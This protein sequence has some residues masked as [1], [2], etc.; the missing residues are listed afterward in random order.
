[1]RKLLPVIVLKCLVNISP[2]FAQD[3]DANALIVSAMGLWNTAQTTDDDAVRLQSLREVRA[4]LQEIVTQHPGSSH[5]VT[6]TI[7]E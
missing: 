5:A 3:A 2:V 7:G 4:A 1:M 6:L